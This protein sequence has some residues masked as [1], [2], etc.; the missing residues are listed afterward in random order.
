MVSET[1]LRH[2]EQDRLL[3]GFIDFQKE[4]ERKERVPLEKIIR[5]NGETLRLFCTHPKYFDQGTSEKIVSQLL[6]SIISLHFLDS[7]FAVYESIPPPES[8]R[9][10]TLMVRYAKDYA[11]ILQVSCVP[12][13][14]KPF[15]TSLAR[16]DLFSEIFPY[17]T[18]YRFCTVTEE[19]WSDCSSVT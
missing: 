8:L 15:I 12:R 16:C 18:R 7:E 10:L 4:L 6:N 3:Q 11:L 13:E 14:G 1:R 9:H 5:E 2:Q 17:F 19:S